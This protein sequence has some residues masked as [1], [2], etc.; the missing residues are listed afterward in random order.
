MLLPPPEQ[1]TPKEEAEHACRCLGQPVHG[2]S[3]LALMYRD[4]CNPWTSATPCPAPSGCCTGG[5]G[6]SSKGSH[7]ASP[8]STILSV[9]RQEDRMACR[10]TWLFRAFWGYSLEN[11]GI[12][13]AEKKQGG[14][15][16]F[17]L[18]QRD[19]FGASSA[20]QR[21]KQPPKRW[22]QQQPQAGP[23][24]KPIRSCRNLHSP[25]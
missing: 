22:N 16:P 15:D 18:G 19:G 4:R 21:S 6:A 24:I 17:Q 8:S 23:G 13:R 25:N 1:Q 9:F 2:S 3:F 20:K 10:W 5:D 14:K 7:P 12:N 11:G